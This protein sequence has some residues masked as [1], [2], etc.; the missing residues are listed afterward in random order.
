MHFIFKEL[1]SLA[2]HYK[3]VSDKQIYDSKSA[4]ENKSC[5]ST[6]ADFESSLSLNEKN[7]IQFIPVLTKILSIIDP[8]RKVL[9]ENN[10][11]LRVLYGY[12]D[13]TQLIKN[14][15]IGNFM[16]IASIGMKEF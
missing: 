9:S 7:A 6:L 14:K 15:S 2:E 13:Q 12:F 5:Y 4:Y 10:E 8:S 16:N 11:D 1:L 3:S